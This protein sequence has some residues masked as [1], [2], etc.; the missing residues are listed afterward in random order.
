MIDSMRSPATRQATI[1]LHSSQEKSVQVEVPRYFSRKLIFMRIMAGLL[2][3]GCAPM[4]LL[5][6][7][8]VRLTSP[9]PALFR[10]IRLGK[11]GKPFEVLKIRTMVHG[12]ENLCGPVLCQPGDSRVT[13][14]GRLL[15]FLHLD[16]VA[17]GDERP[18]V[19][20]FDRAFG[21]I[22]N[23]SDFGVRQAGDKLQI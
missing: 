7:L 8:L 23:F 11:D 6:M 10:Q 16:V 21:T 20:G 5:A 18:V 12:A 9:G 14:I 2:L 17:Q 19:Q 22:Q 3:I 15:R 4:M 13:P 1:A